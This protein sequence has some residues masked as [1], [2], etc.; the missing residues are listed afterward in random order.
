M[1]LRP[2]FSGDVGESRLHYPTQ[3]RTPGLLTIARKG[4]ECMLAYKNGPVFGTVGLPAF[5]TDHI[6]SGITMYL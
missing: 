2:F 5:C 3:R 4:V 6:L 1:R